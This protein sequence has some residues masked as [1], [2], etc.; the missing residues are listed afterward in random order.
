MTRSTFTGGRY[1]AYLI[2]LAILL[3]G[4]LLFAPLST[5][6]AEEGAANFTDDELV[7]LVQTLEDPAERER[8]LGDLKSLLAARQALDTHDNSASAGASAEI[9]SSGQG[10]S[11]APTGEEKGDDIGNRGASSTSGKDRA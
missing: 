8:F 4:L 10:T 5:L 1:G 9:E 11:A 7:E 2:V 3:T 6:T